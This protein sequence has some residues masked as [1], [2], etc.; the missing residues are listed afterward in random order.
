MNICEEK[1]FMFINKKFLGLKQRNIL[2]N[3]KNIHKKI[4]RTNK[5]ISSTIFLFFAFIHILFNQA[6]DLANKKVK[7]FL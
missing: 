7:D 5:G 2:N 4:S 6:K 1:V 3:I